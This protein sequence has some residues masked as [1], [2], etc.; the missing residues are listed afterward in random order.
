MLCSAVI[1]TTCSKTVAGKKWFDNYT[2]TLYD[3][4]INITDS[5]QLHTPFKFGD[6][7]KTFSEKREII[8]AKIGDTECKIDVEIKNAKIPLLLI[9]SSWQR[10][11]IVIDLQ[12]ER[13]KMFDQ[14][15]DKKFSS[16]GH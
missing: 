7:R 13:L 14:C 16:N 4:S 11:N 15:T 3:T 1:D 12:N 9:K 2:K 6:D 8:P 5:F 10:A